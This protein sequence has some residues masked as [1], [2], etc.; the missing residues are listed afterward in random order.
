MK[1]FVKTFGCQANIADSEQMM[2]ILSK[3]HEIV[4]NENIADIIIVNSCSVKNTTEQKVLSYIEKNKK[5][6][7]LVGGCLVKTIDVKERIP[8]VKAVFD[9][10]NISRI[11]E[12]ILNE[13]SLL[14][15]EKEDRINV[16]VIRKH[17]DTGIV[18]I[19]E[20][21]VNNCSFCAT[22]L[23]R[24]NLRSYRKGDIKRAVEK[25]INDG[26]RKIYL[27]SQDNGCYGFDIKT[28]LVELLNELV[29]IEG[30]FI[31]R[32]G[33]MNP[34][35]FDKLKGLVEVYKND[36][37]MKFIHIPVQSGSEKVLKDM[38]RIHTV[39][40]FKEAVKKFRENLD[41]IDIATDVIVGYPTESEEDFLE[42][43]NLIKEVKPEVLNIS[44][45]SAR[46]GTKAKLLKQIDSK[47]VKERSRK[48]HELYWSYRKNEL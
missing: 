11:N 26:C 23:S 46:T 5:K 44:R 21:C 7:V 22:K 48:L 34:W 6:K 39:K 14:S 45:F 25:T 31:I 37:I 28:N 36:R 41:K 42:T 12:V 3:D 29:E 38:K 35:H 13:K 40:N 30:D 18:V 27:T 33:M 1:I 15:K 20:G 9:T 16:N 8:E 43:Y 47:V 10:N 19:G 17:K 24:G 4:N 32:V 2:G